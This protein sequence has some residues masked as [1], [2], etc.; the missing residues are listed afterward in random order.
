[1]NRKMELQMGDKQA[2]R[3]TNR[4]KDR[5]SYSHKDR[6]HDMYDLIFRY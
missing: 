2:N 6:G 5:E 3:Q 4:Q 1:M